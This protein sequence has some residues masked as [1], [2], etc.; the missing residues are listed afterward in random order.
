M[1]HPPYLESY[2]KLPVDFREATLDDFH[3]MGK[4]KIG[5]LFLVLGYH[6]RKYESY[7][8]HPGMRAE[9]LLP[10]IDDHRV[11]IPKQML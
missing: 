2:D 1:E 10:F 4:K 9:G 5:M 3:V 6:S 11:F 7:R 8:V